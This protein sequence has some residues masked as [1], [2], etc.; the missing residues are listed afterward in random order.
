M[1]ISN[2]VAV[3]KFGELD[4]NDITCMECT[5]FFT[6]Y[7]KGIDETSKCTEFRNIVT[8][9]QTRNSKFEYY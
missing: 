7:I 6:V 8:I 1:S 2:L 9:I 4:L 3:V 5:L